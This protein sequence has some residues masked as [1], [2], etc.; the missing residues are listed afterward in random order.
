MATTPTATAPRSSAHAPT[1]P[2][3]TRPPS[4]AL[5]PPSPTTR[6]ASWRSPA[7]RPAPPATSRPP[8]PATPTAAMTPT[9]G[10]PPAAAGHRRAVR[11][12][13]DPA[14]E[15]AEQP[16][17]DHGRLLGHR[18]GPHPDHRAQPAGPLRPHRRGLAGRTHPRHRVG[19]VHDRAVELLVQ[20]EPA[21]PQRPPGPHRHLR[22]RRRQP[23]PQG[24]QQHRRDRPHPDHR[25]RRRGL[26]RLRRAHQDHPPAPGPNLRHLLHLRLHR[27]RPAR[28]PGGQRH[29]GRRP[30]HR[31]AG[32]GQHGLRRRGPAHR[33]VRLRRGHQLRQRPAPHHQLP[34]HRP[35]G[36][37]GH[38]TGGSVQRRRDHH[39]RQLCDQ[40]DHQLGPTPTTANSTPWTCTAP[41]AGAA[42]PHRR[43]RRPRRHLQQRLAHQRPVLPQRA[44]LHP[45]HRPDPHLHRHLRLRRPRQADRHQRRPR[46]PDQLHPGRHPPRLPPTSIRAGNVTTETAVTGATTK[47]TSRCYAG[48][49][50]TTQTDPGGTTSKYWYDQLGRQRCITT[51]TVTDPGVCDHSDGAPADTRLRQLNTYDYLDHLIATRRYRSDGVK[52]D[53]AS[54]VYDALDRIASEHETHTLGAVADRTTTFAYLGLSNQAVNDHQSTVTVCGA[55]DRPTL[56]A[57]K[58]YLYDA[59]G[60]RITLGD[61]SAKCATPTQPATATRYDYG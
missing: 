4:P 61:R 33:P 41:R 3:P 5:S 17:A 27:R 13:P 24:G 37:P 58:S 60:H 21:G 54:Y 30:D 14:L 34:A 10:W 22:L 40:A 31:P 52:T 1:T 55:T 48:T 50:Q 11:H 9:G 19:A 56:T 6:P 36:Q 45:V 25:D 42:D 15:H 20:R 35:G 23:A 16:G 28:Q 32:P 43:L 18:L 57:D 46:H 2:A 49:Q 7:C 51:T 38:R 26:R 12:R 29:R 59:A 39:A 44:R 8:P 47:T 53:S